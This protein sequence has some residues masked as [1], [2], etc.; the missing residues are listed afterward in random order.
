[1]DTPDINEKVRQE[2]GRF[3]HALPGLMAT[4]QGRWVVFKDGQVHSSHETSAEAHRAG[5]QA[6]GVFG[7]QVIARV[8]AEE[9][10]PISAGAYL[11]SP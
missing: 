1:M 10:R 6:F 4:H 7:G 2:M 8:A 11:V 9:P 3:R 5:V